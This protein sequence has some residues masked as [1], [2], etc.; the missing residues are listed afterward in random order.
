VQQKETQYD[1]ANSHN[2]QNP[3]RNR[4]GSESLH[5]GLR[6]QPKNNTTSR[7]PDYRPITML[8]CALELAHRHGTQL[9]LP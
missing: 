9:V 6:S 4:M 1:H 5:D 3:Q 8:H 7:R 2:Y